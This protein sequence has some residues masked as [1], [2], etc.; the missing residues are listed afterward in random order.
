M[1]NFS[2]ALDLGDSLSA[3]E[4]ETEPPLMT[5]PL[6][7]SFTP[8]LTLPPVFSFPLVPIGLLF[9]LE[10]ADML[11]VEMLDLVGE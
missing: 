7:I 6:D 8:D 11:A 5:F 10:S 9:L 1:L 3:L 4:L 2:P